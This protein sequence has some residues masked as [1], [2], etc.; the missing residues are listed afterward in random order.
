M[1]TTIFALSIGP[2]SKLYV[3]ALTPRLSGGT[4]ELK[5]LQNRFLGKPLNG[6]HFSVSYMIFDGIRT[7]KMKYFDV[8]EFF[9]INFDL[10]NRCK[11]EFKDNNEKSCS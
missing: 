2:T 7:S 6:P 1:C 9:R 10:K 5:R 11:N 4:G 8:K 3:L